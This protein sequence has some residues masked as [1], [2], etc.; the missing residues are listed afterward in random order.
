MTTLGIKTSATAT[1]T[2]P[3]LLTAEQVAELLGVSAATVSRWGA[4]REHGADVGPPCYT[5][6]DRVRRWDAA[7]VRAWLRKVRR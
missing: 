3:E 2:F 5:L 6:S 7:E 1:A 4:L